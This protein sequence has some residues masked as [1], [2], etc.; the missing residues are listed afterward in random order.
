MSP[1]LKSV[2]IAGII[3]V[4][5]KNKPYLV[6]PKD[7]FEPID[8]LKKTFARLINCEKSH[9]ISVIPAAS[10]GLANIARN[11]DYSGKSKI[12]IPA[13]QFPSNYY[14]WDRI[15]SEKGLA[16]EIIS[17]PD[18]H[19]GRGRT[20]NEKILE[21]IDNDT[22]VVACG[23]IH[24]ADGTLFDLESFRRACDE[25]NAYLVI[26]GSQSI[27]ALPFDI[28]QIRPDALV[29]VGY[30]WLYGPYGIGFSYTNERFDNGT[31]IEENWKNR[32]QSDDFKSLVNYQEE[33]RPFAGRYD[34]GENSKFITAPMMQTALDQ[35]HGWEVAQIQA[36]SKSLIDPYLKALTDMGCII[37]DE[38]YRCN[39][40]LG[41]RMPDGVDMESLKLLFQSKNLHL[42]IRGSAIRL[43]T[44]VY[45]SKRDLDQFYSIMHNYL[46]L[47]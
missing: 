36:Y 27:G 18:R 12:V 24:W 23:H 11:I 19:V 25:S 32:V 37:E 7:F 44:S 33:Y 16:L 26:D 39:H 35:I 5:S 21:A 38:A 3:G 6:Q 31:P 40:L 46:V 20:W 10:Y 47:A 9:R 28:Q 17:P 29:T 1:N 4:R 14:I 42:S 34:V 45:N 13:E 8:H 2:E 30:K 41:I 43:A 15:A 22:A